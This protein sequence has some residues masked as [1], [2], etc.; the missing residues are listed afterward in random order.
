[1]ILKNSRDAKKSPAPPFKA[2]AGLFHRLMRGA[3]APL[4]TQVAPRPKM[5]YVN[6]YIDLVFKD[7][8]DGWVI[9]DFKTH[10]SKEVAHDIRGSYDK[11]LNIYKEVWEKITGEPVVKTDVFFIMKRV[12]GQ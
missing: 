8:D 5:V 2:S 12:Q 10:D 1:M 6:G 7:D 9:I 4:A 11:Q 3:S